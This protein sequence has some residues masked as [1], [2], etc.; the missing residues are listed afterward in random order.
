MIETIEMT[1]DAQER[2][3][4]YLAAV[5][6]STAGTTMDAD[7]MAGDVR[8]HVASALASVPA[9]I[10]RG[11]VDEVL[12]RLG[13]PS[14]WVA[15]E[16][17]P[18]LRRILRR[19]ASGPEDWRLAYL[20]LGLTAVGL[21]TFPFGGFVLVAVAWLLA[22]AALDLMTIEGRA[23]A[24]KRWLIYPPLVLVALVLGTLVVA[25]PVPVLLAWGV[26]DEQL[27]VVLGVEAA[28]L[29]PA[30]WLRLT[31]GFGLACLGAWWLVLSGLLALLLR[32]FRVLWRPFIDRIKRRHAL[33]LT[34]AGGVLG[35]V[36]LLLLA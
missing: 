26:G 6:R 32:P 2:L 19:L 5:R 16:E 34:A 22:R 31:W 11:D 17:L 25:G 18:P 10:S 1:P 13:R 8:D 24:P 9:P 7:E 14:D 28:Q 15:E 4:T 12:D 27:F 30:E 33:W 20:T 3:R 29:A 36:G 21:L 35:L 23:A